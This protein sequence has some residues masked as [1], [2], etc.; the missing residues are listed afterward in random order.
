[1]EWTVEF[2][3]GGSSYELV[4]GGAYHAAFVA[5]DFDR[6]RG[7][8]DGDDPDADNWGDDAGEKD[9]AADARCACCALWD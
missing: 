4:G 2:A 9:T 5:A 7:Y 8:D 6:G 3:G 1:M